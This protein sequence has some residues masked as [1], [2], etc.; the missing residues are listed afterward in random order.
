MPVEWTLYAIA[1]REGSTG[2]RMLE[3]LKWTARF[4]ETQGPNAIEAGGCK[5]R[6]TAQKL[7]KRHVPV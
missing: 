7:G 2:Q 6:E 4:V 3:D 5:C 1:E